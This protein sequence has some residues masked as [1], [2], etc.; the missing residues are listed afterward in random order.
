MKHIA[1]VL[2]VLSTTTLAAAEP[3]AVTGRYHLDVEVDPT[4]YAFSGY[5][6]HVGAGYEHLRLDL[7]VYGLEVPAFLHG[8]EGWDAEFTGAGAKLQW[9]PFAAQR[10]LFVDVSGGVTRQRVTL[11]ET[12]AS[13]RDTVVGAG[14]D[15]GWR[16]ALPYR[17]YVT[18]WAGVGYDFNADDV[19]IGG[20]TF[21]RSKLVPFAAVHVGFRFR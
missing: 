11:E 2:A 16:F 18:P 5:S 13:R 20:K 15:A 3:P 10:G 14:L 4:A 7:G 21:T 8:N 17:F 9:F 19:M 12:G 6:L 1:I